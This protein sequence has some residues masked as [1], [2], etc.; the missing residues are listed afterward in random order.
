MKFDLINYKGK[1]TII[2][3]KE[4][5]DEY[6]DEKVGEIDFESAILQAENRVNLAMNYGVPAYVG[7]C[8]HMNDVYERFYEVSN[9]ETGLY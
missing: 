4:L 3:D 5:Y 1:F 7:R 6:Y 8:E 9:S 2:Q